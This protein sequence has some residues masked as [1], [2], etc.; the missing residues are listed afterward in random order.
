MVRQIFCL[1]Y[2]CVRASA[3][4]NHLMIYH[5]TIS[6]HLNSH[7]HSSYSIKLFEL[8]EDY[9]NIYHEIE[10]GERWWDEMVVF[11]DLFT[12][13]LF[14]HL[15]INICLTIYHV[16]IDL[17]DSSISSSHMIIWLKDTIGEMMRWDGRSWDGRLR[18][19]IVD[20]MRDERW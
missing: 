15:I 10:N 9:E 4:T 18:D 7:P 19:E 6:S 5:L 2:F 1:F 12:F 17:I 16:M 20:E 11:D 13:H 8:L 14:Y 3:R